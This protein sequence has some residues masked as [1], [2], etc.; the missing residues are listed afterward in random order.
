MNRRQIRI[1]IDHFKRKLH[2]S[3]GLNFRRR[4]HKIQ[5]DAV[6]YYLI[7]ALQIALVVLLA[8]GLTA[9]FGKRVSCAGESMADTIPENG[10]VWLNRVTYHLKEP[11]RGDVIAFYPKGNVNANYSIKRI[12]AVPG[13]TVLIAN[14][15]L[16]VNEQV[17][18]LRQEDASIQEAGRAATAITL[19]EDEY[20]VLGDNRNNSEDSRFAN[21]GNVKEEYIIG[22]AWFR[23][24][25]ISSMGF[26]K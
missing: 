13:D 23:I 15:R 6:R 20:F 9:G 26:I 22:K 16:Y 3:D 10:N 2:I 25:S 11:Q 7:W 17:T 21:I 4:R 19:G 1:Y 24:S 5:G 12:V 8:F 18:R 14:G